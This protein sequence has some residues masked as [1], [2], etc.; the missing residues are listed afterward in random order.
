MRGHISKALQARSPAIK[1]ALDKYNTSAALLSPPAPQ[2]SWKQI[3]DYAFL[4]DFDLLRCA[5]QDIREKPWANPTNR[6]LRDQYF[7]LECAREEIERL[8]VEIRRL[9]TYMRD[10][11]AFLTKC[12]SEF[13]TTQ[14]HIAHQIS[15]YRLERSRSNL[16]HKRR[17][18]KLSL[19]A[20]FTGNMSPGIAIGDRQANSIPTHDDVSNDMASDDPEDESDEEE[21]KSDAEEN[22]SDEEDADHLIEDIAYSMLAVSLDDSSES[23]MD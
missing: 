16:Q 22:E 2:L 6:T 4:S 3:V 5:R 12:E 23:R 13:K 14:S 8:N 9:V 11:E 7:K 10:E 1:T 21:A 15:L 20:H 17:F 19:S 18:D